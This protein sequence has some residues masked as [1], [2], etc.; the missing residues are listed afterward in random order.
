M[1]KTTIFFLP[2]SRYR[3]EQTGRST[4]EGGR[5]AG[6]P[7]HGAAGKW[8]KTKRRSRA[9]HSAPHLGRGRTATR[10]GTGGTGGSDGELGEEGELVVEVRDEVGSRSGPF[11]GA[12]RS[13]RRRYL[14]TRSFD[15]RQWRWGE[16]YPGIDLGSASFRAARRC[17]WDSSCRRPLW[18]WGRRPAGGEK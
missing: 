10:N 5:G 17:G 2:P 14:S 8:G 9:T 7:G 13:V 4:G 12:G 16:K 1:G 11:I 18:L 3:M 15:G 6:D